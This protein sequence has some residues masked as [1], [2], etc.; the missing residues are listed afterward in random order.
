[1]HRPSMPRL[2]EQIRGTLDA[3]FFHGEGHRKV[4]ARLRF[5]GL[6]TSR[7][8]VLRLMRECGLLAL[9]RMGSPR[10]PRNHGGAV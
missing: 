3:S 8:R 7:H 5:A 10:G 6:R 9:A 2:L 1:M 4:L